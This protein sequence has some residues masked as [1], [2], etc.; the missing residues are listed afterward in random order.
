[1][2]RVDVEPVLEIANRRTSRAC[3]VLDRVGGAFLQRHV[4][5]H[6]ADH[7][8]DVLTDRGPVV[9]TA[10][11][12][13]ARDVDVVGKLDDY[14]LTGEAFVDL[15]AAGLVH[16]RHRGREAGRQHG[17]LVAGLERPAR[18]GACVTTEVVELAVLGTDHV[19]HRQARVDEI[20]VRGDVQA[21]EQAQQRLPVV[22]GHRLA[23]GHDVVAGQGRHRDEGEVGHLELH[24]ERAELLADLVVALLRVVDQV[25]LVDAH[26]QVRD[27]EQRREEGMPARLL[28]HTVAGV[29]QDQRDVGGGRTGDHVARVLD[30]ARRVGDDEL[31]ARRGEVPVCDID[32]DALLALGAQAVGEQRQVRAFVATGDAGRF[33]RTELVFEDGLAV[34]E[35][36]ADQGRLAVVD[37][38]G[39]GNAQQLRHYSALLF[40]RALIGSFAALLARWRSLRCSLT[41]NT[42]PSCGLPCRLR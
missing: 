12:V 8:V 7:R 36:P 20:A 21:F 1:M 17:D 37:R 31:A 22:P 3:R 27:A 14:G 42:L 32:R 28:E 33:D 24:G 5:R 13:A 11:H 25:H 6:P 4:R 2:Q 15:L 39:R 35:Q 30:V 29:D 16:C 40:A 38:T 18:D 23:A 9:R 26:E 34:I 41:R 19:L 10:D